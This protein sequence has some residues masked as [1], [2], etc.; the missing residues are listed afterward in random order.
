MGKAMDRLESIVADVLERT[1][2]TGGQ[3]QLRLEEIDLPALVE[4]LRL[5]L[6]A[7]IEAK[8]LRL[9][10]EVSAGARRA[11]SDPRV[12]RL[13]LSNLLGN[14][15][16]YTDGGAVELRAF[17][18]AGLVFTVSDSGRGIDPAD[19]ERIFEPFEH[20]ERIEH[21]STPGLGLGLALVRDL[22]AALGGRL[23]LQSEKGVGSLFTVTLPIRRS[24]GE[25]PLNEAV[26][27]L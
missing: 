3:L 10:I 20:G 1:R 24:G 2:I 13:I 8:G 15:I 12:L 27:D 5:E 14:A 11:T 23:T 22:V 18:D 17:L 7:A 9:D 19:Q 25:Q 6:A 21:K 26:G 16:K 4:G